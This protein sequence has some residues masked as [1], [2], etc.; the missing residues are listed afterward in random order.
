[1]PHVR[2]HHRHGAC[3][4]N[5]QDLLRVRLV[6]IA[7]HILRPRSPR[8]R[9]RNHAGWPVLAGEVVEQPH[10]V[11]N[12]VALL[13]GYRAHV[14]VKRLTGAGRRIRR[15]C[16]ETA[17]LT[18]LADDVF[19]QVQDLWKDDRAPEDFA[20]VDQVREAMRVLLLSELMAGPI[21][22]F[23]E[24][25]EDAT[26]QFS[27][28]GAIDR[29]FEDD[30]SLVIEMPLLLNSHAFKYAPPSP[31]STHVRR[32]LKTPPYLGLFDSR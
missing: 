17:Q 31:S 24:Q 15:P 19:H 1:M 18:V 26:A 22:F 2:V 27:K 32:G 13:V 14:D 5:Q 21:A 4:R 11:A 16:I 20:L 3:R 12:P 9:P 28:K 10:G 23:V 8:V 6:R 7:H 30:V 29:G 25:L